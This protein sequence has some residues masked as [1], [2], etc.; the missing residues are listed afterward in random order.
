MIFR[1]FTDRRRVA[2]PLPIFFMYSVLGGKNMQKKGSNRFRDIQLNIRITEYEKML[3][4]QNMKE[5]GA[6]SMQDY[7]IQIATKGYILNVDYSDMRG[8]AYE[9]NKIGTNINQ[10]A[11][12]I[13]SENRIYQAQ[14]N[15][16]QDNMELI[17]KVIRNK[18]QQLP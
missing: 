4:Q 15:E 9:L 8:I 18:F 12:K 7:I 3:I 1:S 13:N 17:W 10:I 5:S 16:L 6:R 14:M 11:H 2:D